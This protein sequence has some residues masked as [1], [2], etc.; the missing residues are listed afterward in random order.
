MR[1]YIVTL[2]NEEKCRHFDEEKAKEA[3]SH[4]HYTD[5]AG[6]KHEGAHWTPEQV[7][8][9]TAQMKFPEGTT[10]W[11]K[12]VAFN[13][14]FSILCKKF[15]ECQIIQIGYMFFFADDGNKMN[16][17]HLNIWDSVC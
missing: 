17:F 14:A 15:D 13:I 11:D 10:K 2:Q 3:V 5:K 12:Y 16:V 7:E 9:A 4:I 8:S 1:K 6:V